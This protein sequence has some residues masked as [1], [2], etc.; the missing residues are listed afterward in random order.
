MRK[1][2]LF[3]IREINLNRYIITKYINLDIYILS[4]YNVNNRPIEI[5]LK[6]IILIINNLKIKIFITINIFIYENI[7]L[8][9]FTRIDYINNYYIL[10]N[11]NIILFIKPFI[12]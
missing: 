6:Y 5:L 7:D 8:I 11:L 1:T 4:Y 2:L 9:I 3:V 10:F 12:K